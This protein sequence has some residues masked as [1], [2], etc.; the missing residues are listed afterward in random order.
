MY[1]TVTADLFFQKPCQ[2]NLIL[3][4]YDPK[5]D[6]LCCFKDTHVLLLIVPDV[7]LHSCN[8]YSDLTRCTPASFSMFGTTTCENI[9]LNGIAISNDM[10]VVALVLCL[11]DLSEH[12]FR[13]V[14]TDSSEI[15]YVFG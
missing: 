10:A 3:A 7:T 6:L 8:S 1:N 5:T 13:S 12:E 4:G 15:T 2:F 9:Q 14:V 11:F